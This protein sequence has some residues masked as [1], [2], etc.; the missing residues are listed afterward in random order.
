MVFIRSDEDNRTLV[1][2][3]VLAQLILVFERR[4]NAQPENTDQ[5]VDRSGR[6]RS[7]EHDGVLVGG[8]QAATNDRPGLL[9]EAGGL[10]AGS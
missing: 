1:G 10:Q 3:D 8:A 6:A 7:G 4:G 2:R 5:L 9:T